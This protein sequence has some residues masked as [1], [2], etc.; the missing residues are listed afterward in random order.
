MLKTVW[1]DT[2]REPIIDNNPKEPFPMV[3][4]YNSLGC[5]LLKKYRETLKKNNFFDKFLIINAYK[6]HASLRRMLIRSELRP[7]GIVENN[8][9][10]TNSDNSNNNNKFSLCK[11][12]DCLTCKF[13]SCSNTNFN[14][15]TFGSTHNVIGSMNC[16]TNN[17]VYLITCIKCN[18]QY[19]GETSRCLAERLTDHRSNIKHNKITPIAIH[20]NTPGHSALRDLKAMAIEKISDTENPLKKR[21]QQESLWQKRL[22]TIYPYGLNCYPCNT[23]D[24]DL[25]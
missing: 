12:R 1:F 13:H 18:I 7:T 2:S 8:L 9:I 5:D 10:T 25:H 17:I 14:S 20:F 21:K 16:R 24:T 4:Q 3:M 15:S 11:N 23:Y 6:N 19:V 22:G